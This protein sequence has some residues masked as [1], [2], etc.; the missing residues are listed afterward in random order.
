MKHKK[1]IRRILE[2]VSTK[3]ILVITLLVLPMNIF[4]IKQSNEALDIVV[5]QGR[6]SIEDIVTIQI[7]ELNKRMEHQFFL[8]SYFLTNDTNC[9]QMKKQ[10]YDLY[11]YNRTKNFFYITLKNMTSMSNGADGYFYYMHKKD[12]FLIYNTK[13]S[14]KDTENQIK[15]YI[16]CNVNT[17]DFL[18]WNITEF[19]GEKYYILT[20]HLQDFT[21]GGWFNLSDIENEI[22]NMIEYKSCQLSCDEIEYEGNNSKNVYI[23]METN[24]LWFNISVSRDELVG[25]MT[26]TQRLMQ[27]VAFSMLLLIPLLYL[28]MHRLLIRPLLTLNRAHFEIKRG[29]QKYRIMDT[30]SSIEYRDAYRSFNE[31]SDTIETLRIESYEKELSK[32]KMELKNLQLQIRPHFLQNT[33]NLIFTLIQRK[34]LSV[35]QDIVLYISEYFRYI[36]RTEKEMELFDK[37]L[38]LIEGYMNM[39]AVRYDHKISMEYDMDPEISFVRTPP[40]LIHNFIENAVKHAFDGE[41]EMIVRLEGTYQDKMVTFTISDNGNG[42]SEEIVEKLRCSLVSTNE[43]E[44]IHVG[45]KNSMRR[46]KYFYGTDASIFIESIEGKG[47]SFVI[48]FPYNL[49]EDI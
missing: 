14:N 7:N 1:T 33:F 16:R 47:T 4:A 24:S 40:L 6:K 26:R 22:R 32:Q 39:V 18:G 44:N 49:E 11:E 41:R 8:M 13:Y 46:L 10:S 12:D 42:M 29:N 43:E 20:L 48:T 27:I 21:Y 35:L 9:Q 38:K 30:A 28:L 31:M 15:E 2:S 19:A 34:E 3:V 36:F 37:E 23:I 45:L 17:P 5:E 25:N